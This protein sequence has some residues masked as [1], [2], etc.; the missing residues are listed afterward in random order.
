MNLPQQI[1]SA[2]Y[3]SYTW[4]RSRSPGYAFKTPE[5]FDDGLREQITKL[6]GWMAYKQMANLTDAS[7]VVGAP[8]RTTI[9]WGVQDHLDELLCAIEQVNFRVLRN[10]FAYKDDEILLADTTAAATIRD[11]PMIIVDNL[12]NTRRTVSKFATKL[13]EVGAAEIHLCILARWIDGSPEAIQVARDF[14]A[15]ICSNQPTHRTAPDRLTARE[16]RLLYT[17]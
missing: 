15:S 8:P 4:G 2:T 10:V 13:A 7:V 1:Q 6:F 17:S 14:R 5:K 9:K 11:R 16:K 3:L 12:L